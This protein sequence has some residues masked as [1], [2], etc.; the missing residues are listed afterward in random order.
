MNIGMHLAV[1]T[2]ELFMNSKDPFQNS[3]TEKLPKNEHSSESKEQKQN[4]K[5]NAGVDP[6]HLN[7]VFQEPVLAFALHTPHIRDLVKTCIFVLDTN[8]LMAAYKFGAGQAADISTVIRKLA[9][10][11]R[12]FIPERAAQ[13]FARN[14]HIV[15]ST[16]YNTLHNWMSTLDKAASAD[17]IQCPMLEACDSYKHFQSAT[18]SL[19]K[20]RNDYKK[21]LSNLMGE[22]VDWNWSDPIS[23]L[24]RSVFTKDRLIGT[25][26]GDQKVYDTLNYRYSHRQPPGFMDVAKRDDGIGDLLIWDSMK[27]CALKHK[28]NIVF[29]SGDEKNDWAVKVQ[30]T[31]LTVRPELIH[32]FYRET[33]MHFGLVDFTMF[34]KTNGAKEDTVN[35]AE[36]MRIAEL[37]D[38]D[39]QHSVWVNLSRVTEI[40]ESYVASRKTGV[41][42]NSSIGSWE[43][44]ELVARIV[45]ANTERLSRSIMP[46]SPERF[47][48]IKRVLIQIVK[49]SER[50]NS[51]TSR[52]F[53]MRKNDIAE[54]KGLCRGYLDLVSGENTFSYSGTT[55]TTTPPPDAYWL[56]PAP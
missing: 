14:R 35:Q 7:K 21:S 56:P 36:N 12:L 3:P 49:V 46:M 53:D 50:I 15:L 39:P 30:K 9:S 29:V 8:V 43:F 20:A 37:Q 5:D 2:T 42:R 38:S 25:A 6:L 34:L 22:L 27:A 41:G 31:V 51:G 32:E 11:N 28:K 48:S 10:Q 54:L 40:I 17:T 19:S 13:E 24:Y 44:H 55:T 1:Q 4:S 18:D 16:A 33:Q 52:T 47:D 23:E 45:P 26:A